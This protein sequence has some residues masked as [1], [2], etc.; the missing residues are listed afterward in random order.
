MKGIHGLIVAAGLGIAGAVF[1]LFYLS[2]KAR[3]IEK[4]SF[5][6]VKPDAVIARGER[7][8]TDNLVEV[9]IPRS[10]VGNLKDFAFPWSDLNT[11]DRV[12]VWRTLTGGALLL[13]DD[14][15]TPPPELELEKGDVAMAIP[16]DTRTFAL[17]LLTPGDMV[18]F[19]VPRAST[20]LP[21]RAVPE[22]APKPENLDDPAPAIPAGPTETIGPFKI[23][24]IGNRLGSAEVMLAAKIPQ[25]QENILTI[26][27]S[28]QVA[29]E[30]ERADKL[31]DRLQAV[32]F[33]N[34]GIELQDRKSERN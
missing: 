1:N 10:A 13:R 4:V 16:V 31:W 12:P 32:G 24:A 22:G 34:V 29:G 5:I 33:R 2:S 27:K 6:G 14:V 21:T 15:R 19:K 28:K 3:E 26:R 30:V 11:V 17:S 8:S 18:W 20:V 7:L 23:L 25:M 9:G